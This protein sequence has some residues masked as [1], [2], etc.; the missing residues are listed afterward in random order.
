MI[1]IPMVKSGPRPNAVE[2]MMTETEA[3]RMVRRITRSYHHPRRTRYPAV[4][5]KAKK[6]RPCREKRL[7]TGP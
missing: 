5:K 6:M 4:I 3:M 2:L 1:D 7:K